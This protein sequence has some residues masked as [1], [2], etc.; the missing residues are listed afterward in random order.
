MSWSLV[1]CL[2]VHAGAFPAR[3]RTC[4]MSC[5]SADVTVAMWRCGC[6]SV[7][8]SPPGHGKIDLSSP[9]HSVRTIRA[10]TS[11]RLQPLA[12]TFCCA[13]ACSCSAQRQRLGAICAGKPGIRHTHRAQGKLGHGP[14][15]ELALWA[16]GTAVACLSP[17]HA[18]P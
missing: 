9:R 11:T 4:I 17:A 6:G 16:A 7:V 8:L 15:A 2:A 1:L 18:P 14:S 12:V 3:C 13:Y 5:G 10:C